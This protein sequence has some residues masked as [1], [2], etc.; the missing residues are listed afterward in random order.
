[1]SKVGLAKVSE[2]SNEL[3][4][5][6]DQFS[7]KWLEDL[8][9]GNER[10]A[11]QLAFFLRAIPAETGSLLLVGSGSGQSAYFI[12]SEV[13]PNAKIKALDISSEGLR[14]AE[15]LFSD[16]RIE[17]QRLD[18]LTEP[19]DGQWDG[20]VLPDIYEHIPVAARSKLHAK[21]NA[22]LS[23]NGKIFMTLPSPGKQASLYASGKGLQIVDETVTL[24]DLVRMASE[25]GGVLT[26]FNMVSVWEN[27]D[28]IHAVIE[29]GA[30]TVGPIE[31]I[32]QTPLKGWPRRG[33]WVR[34]RDFL[35]NRFHIFKILQ[36][37]KRRRLQ[38]RLLRAQGDREMAS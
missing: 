8:V 13:A 14:L 36:T 11:Q 29:R 30:N 7:R 12:A 1:M 20:I 32:N 34:G 3:E 27:N 6:Y 38:A 18:I 16:G 2:S 22:L 10:I 35:G 17:Y 26:Y 5:F 4:N 25:T 24:E 31:N 28:Y 21:F 37:L 15:T 23:P 33:L 19:V 9:Q